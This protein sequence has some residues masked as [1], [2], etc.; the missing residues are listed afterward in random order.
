MKIIDLLNKIAKG[1]EVPKKISINGGIHGIDVW[2]YDENC[3]DY[4]N[5][6]NIMLLYS[7]MTSNHLTDEVEVLEEVEDKEYED[8]EELGILL[9]NESYSNEILYGTINTLIR[10]QQK[11]IEQLENK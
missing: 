4:L 7:G 10:N 9:D 6:S 11:I 8:I 3:K 2:E 5:S 1:E